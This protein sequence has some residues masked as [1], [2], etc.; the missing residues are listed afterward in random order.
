VSTAGTG[1]GAVSSS[2]GQIDCPGICSASY[3]AGTVVTLTAAVSIGSTFG[4]WSGACS[5]QSLTCTVTMDAAKSATATFTSATP[6]TVRLSVRVVG[7]AGTG[8]VTS[9]PSG[10]SCGAGSTCALDFVQGTT[11][12]LNAIGLPGGAF[13]QWT[14][15]PCAGR[16]T[17]SCT[18][19]LNQATAVTAQF[20]TQE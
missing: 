1:S 12:T 9:S 11:V 16:T 17:P 15:G 4:G 14:A 6:T 8:I 3:N 7:A 20:R 5:G 19:V 18:V 10:I 2:P 13:E